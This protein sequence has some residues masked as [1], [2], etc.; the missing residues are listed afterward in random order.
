VFDQ[1]ELR[2]N[3]ALYSDLYALDL[4]TGRVSLLTRDARLRDPDLTP[5]GRAIVA[6]RQRDGDRALAVL[7]LA[8]DD[9]PVRV[10]SVQTLIADPDTQ[11]NAPRWAPDGRWIAVERHGPGRLP[12]IVLVDSETSTLHELAAPP[13]S[14]VVTPAW[15]PDGLAVLAAADPDG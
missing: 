11:F 10:E 15:R 8:R 12:G 6:V 7:R 2:R 9:G 13:G 4:A 5:D 3:T 14:A 1:L